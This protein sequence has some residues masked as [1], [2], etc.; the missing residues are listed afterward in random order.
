[1]LRKNI[2]MLSLKAQPDSRE[3]AMLRKIIFILSLG[4]QPDSGEMGMLRKAKKKTS[5]KKPP[6]TSFG[7]PN[8]GDSTPWATKVVEF[9][10]NLCFLRYQ[11]F[12]VSLHCR[13]GLQTQKH[14]FI[15]PPPPIATISPS[16][17]GRA[18]NGLRDMPGTLQILS[19]SSACIKNPADLLL[20]GSR[21][22]PGRIPGASR[23]L[24]G[25]TFHQY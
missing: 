7:N 12:S 25:T 20:G 11:I 19:K 23:D 3:M 8:R 13:K 14:G 10:E 16:W 22:A 15:V 17:L 5:T 9:G 21:E 6:G 18:P 1:M 4:P 2:F 24:P